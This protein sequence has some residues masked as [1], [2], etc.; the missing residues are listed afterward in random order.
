LR[1]PNRFGENVFV[2]TEK[3]LDDVL[4]TARR[5]RVTEGGAYG[6]RPLGGVVLVDERDDAA[7]LALR[8]ALAV[9][10]TTDGM[11]MCLGDLAFEFF[12]ADGRRTAVVGFHHAHS[13]RWPGWSGDALLADGVRVLHWLADR[14]ADGPLEREEARHRDRV[15]AQVAQQRWLAAVPAAVRDLGDAIVATSR[16]GHAPDDLLDLLRQR[17]SEAYPDPVERAGALLAWFGSGT[18]RCSGFP[19]HEGLPGLLLAE[20]PIADIVGAL[21][22][23]N[24]DTR[25]DEGAIRHLSGW[26]SRKHQARDIARVPAQ[27]RARLLA[28]ARASGD[29][30]KRARAERWL[31][32]APTPRS[33]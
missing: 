22:R 15:E 28:A 11:C 23:L 4:Q 20:M 17:L 21:Q 24:A 5:V 16:T 6:G 19:V 30:D 31:G 10:R 9:E 14:G 32:E 29:D 8:H 18:G 13:L 12:D 3:A 27:L 26:K 7:L 1:H 2:T 25:Q 33:R